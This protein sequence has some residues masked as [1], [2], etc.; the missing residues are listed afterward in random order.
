MGDV[1]R[2]SGIGGKYLLPAM[3]KVS[4]RHAVG[5]PAV[6]VSIGSQSEA[7]ITA[8]FSLAY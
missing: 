8:S 4:F 5:F 2:V 6:P 7:A 1:F 3:S